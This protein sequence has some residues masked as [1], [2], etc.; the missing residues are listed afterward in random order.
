MLANQGT[1][2]AGLPKALEWG[3]TATA[4]SGATAIDATTELGTSSNSIQMA[5]DISAIA[6]TV[7]ESGSAEKIDTQAVKARAGEYLFF[8]RTAAAGTAIV[9]FWTGQAGMGR[10][11]LPAESTTFKHLEL[12]SFAQPGN[13]YT[14]TNAQPAV[15]LRVPT[16]AIKG[17]AKYYAG[18]Q[19][20]DNAA[21]TAVKFYTTSLQVEVIARRFG[22]ADKFKESLVQPNFQTVDALTAPT[23][24]SE[25]VT[26]APDSNSEWLTA[27]VTGKKSYWTGSEVTNAIPGQVVA[28]SLPNK[29]RIDDILT[30]AG[31][32]WK[33]NTAT[34]A[35][36]ERGSYQGVA[37]TT[38]DPGMV[39]F[40]VPTDADETV[41][42]TKKYYAGLKIT[43][44]STVQYLA[45]SVA[46]KTG[47]KGA[48][49]K[50]DGINTL[51]TGSAGSADKI[52]TL[53]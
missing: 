14:T 12:W 23:T 10:F 15:V 48:N 47:A 45:V 53:A 35:L 5:T 43:N 26:T 29:C 32:N 40:M 36:T 30:T 42:T 25:I 52:V 21:N 18:F 46:L 24:G 7:W 49:I 27:T 44:D 8:Q 22:T 16:A 39:S 11:T 51:F 41:A 50:S 20:A 9:N 13:K 37:G 33:T 2:N 1:V 17:S 38:T 19:I 28:F 6:N 4:L 3:F 34:P 31:T